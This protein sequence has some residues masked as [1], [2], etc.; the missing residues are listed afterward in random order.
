MKIIT[1]SPNQTKKTGE[2]LAKEILKMPKKESAFVLGLEGDLG[3]GKTTFLQGFAKGL[4]IKE[5][6][7]SPTFVILKKFEIRN[8]KS[9]TNFKSQVPKFKNFY[10]IDCYRIQKPREILDLGFEK[11]ISTPENIV[12][13]EWAGRIRKN[14]PRDAFWLKFE[15]LNQ[16]PRKIK[17][18]S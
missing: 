11:M 17:I 10:H 7:L 5:K 6:I 18:T 8:P 4:E 12:A 13:I 16:K 9:E 14:I 1:Q 2:I 3:G 15:F